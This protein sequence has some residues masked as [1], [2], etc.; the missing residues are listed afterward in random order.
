MK[1][2]LFLFTTLLLI[3]CSSDDGDDSLVDDNTTNTDGNSSGN[4]SGETL[5]FL[6]KYD[7][8][9]FRGEFDGDTEYFYFY[10]AD[11]F[12]GFIAQNSFCTVCLSPQEGTNTFDGEEGEMKIL[13]NDSQSLLI[14][15]TY[16]G[17]DS[18][19]L[20]FVVDS[21]GNNLTVTYD[22][23]ANDT[24]T[25]VKTSTS[26]SSLCDN[27]SSD[28]NA[29][30][31]FFG[32]WKGIEDQGTIDET[33]FNFFIYEDGTLEWN[34]IDL[35]DENSSTFDVFCTGIYYNNADYPDFSNTTQTYFM[36][37]YQES[38]SGNDPNGE[39]YFEF[40]SEGEVVTIIFNDD[41][42][43]FSPEGSDMILYKQ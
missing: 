13:T 16:D 23:D 18:E 5:T 37:I 43:Q 22:G 31:P 41:L 3:S 26:Y 34:A 25:Y 38:C 7:G 33:E 12:L 19:T 32:H 17:D 36:Q 11:V 2:L 1:K 4:N 35:I 10:D 20:Q 8:Y 42:T 39:I 15:I 6:E 9:G 27:N 24:D 40:E 21:T 14:E 29:V 28:C 30:D